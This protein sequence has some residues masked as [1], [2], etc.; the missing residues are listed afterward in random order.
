MALRAAGNNRFEESWRVKEL[1]SAYTQQQFAEP[2]VVRPHDFSRQRRNAR[3]PFHECLGCFPT[4]M[5]SGCGAFRLQQECSF[6]TQVPV[7]AAKMTEAPRR[8]SRRLASSDP[9]ST[10]SRR[11]VKTI[12]PGFSPMASARTVKSPKRMSSS[13]TRSMSASDNRTAWLRGTLASSGCQPNLNNTP[14]P[15]RGYSHSIS[16]VFAVST[17]QVPHSKQPSTVIS[18]WPLSLRL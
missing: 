7:W 4:G 16:P 1:P 17:R 13:R 2:R 11:A 6:S 15:P 14:Y 10:R 12:R 8:E 9:Q 18:T 3:C 5:K